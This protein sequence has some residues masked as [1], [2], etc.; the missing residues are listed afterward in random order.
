MKH[1]EAASCESINQ[2]RTLLK[3]LML[4]VKNACK[5]IMAVITLRK[6]P[7]IMDIKS[8]RGVNIAQINHFYFLIFTPWICT[9][10]QVILRFVLKWQ[11][12]NK[13]IPVA[14]QWKKFSRYIHLSPTYSFTGENNNLL[15]LSK[16][17]AYYQD[18]TIM[19]NNGCLPKFKF[20][21]FKH[22]IICW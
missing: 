2:V 21:Y 15:T 11:L 5:A 10:S 9:S 1:W 6:T 22:F 20:C 14:S 18:G 12:Q 13:Q 16:S 17:R 8:N 4:K 7:P 3:N 19:A